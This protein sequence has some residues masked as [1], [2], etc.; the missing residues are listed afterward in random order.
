MV[1]WYDIFMQTF[2]SL[3]GLVLVLFLGVSGVL[4]LMRFLNDRK[5]EEDLVFLQLLVPKKE[6]RE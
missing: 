1:Y 5:R 4:W 3:I 6:S 2:Q